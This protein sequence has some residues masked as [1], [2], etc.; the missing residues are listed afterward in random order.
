MFNDIDFLIC[1]I[2]LTS[3][4][5]QKFFLNIF[6]RNFFAE[7]VLFIQI[8]LIHFCVKCSIALISQYTVLYDVAAINKLNFWS[9]NKREESQ[10]S[11]LTELLG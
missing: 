2:S 9:I 1:D 10:S 4:S 6:Q 8:I 5:F 7:H 11:D 3:K